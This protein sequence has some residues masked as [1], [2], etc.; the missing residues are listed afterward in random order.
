[1]FRSAILALTAVLVLPVPHAAAAGLIVYG[2]D[3]AFSVAEPPGWVG[4]TESAAQMDANIVLYRR[5]QPPDPS[6]GMIRVRVNKKTD[7]NTAADLEADENAYRSR[8]PKVVFKSL[9]VSHPTYSVSSKLFAV[10]DEFYE[11]VTYLNPGPS[12]HF[13]LSISMNTGK[14]AASEEELKAYQSVVA[15]IVAMAHAALPRD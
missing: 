4:D 15:S 10:P 11:Y 1:M 5:G 12:L 8:Y 3:F 9:A 13:M 7:E 6:H 14:K 2:T